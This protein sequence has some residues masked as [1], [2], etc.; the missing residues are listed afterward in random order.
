M[1][2]SRG[3]RFEYTAS[4]LPGVAFSFLAGVASGLLG[5]G[6]GSVMV[7]VMSLLVGIPMHIAVATSAFMIVFTSSS[8]AVTHFLQGNVVLEY[9]VAL[10]LG[11][12]IGAQVGAR[13]ARRIRAGRLRK[14]FGLFLFLIGLRMAVPSL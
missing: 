2:D 12:V 11:S 5:I 13:L 1:V 6:G 4:I 8:A 14:V 10:A 3:V 7:P 9:A